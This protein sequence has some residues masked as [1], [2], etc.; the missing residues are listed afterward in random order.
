MKAPTRRRS[1]LM[2]VDNPLVVLHLYVE[3]CKARTGFQLVSC[4]DLDWYTRV[5]DLGGG[6]PSPRAAKYERQGA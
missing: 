2:E 1:A 3:K 5:T 6:S 4:S